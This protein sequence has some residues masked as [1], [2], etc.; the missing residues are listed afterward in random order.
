MDDHIVVCEGLCSLIGARPDMHIVGEASNGVEAVKNALA[1]HPDVILMDLV[2]PVMGGIEAIS[3][4]KRHDP[5][6]RILVLTSFNEDRRVYEAVKRGALG[7]LLKDSS[8][9]DLIRAVQQV[10]RGELSLQPSI[11]LKVIRELKQPS[12]LP[13]TT[14]PLSARE[15]DVLRLVARGCSVRGAVGR[16]YAV[17]IALG[18]LGILGARGPAIGCWILLGC[19]SVFALGS[20]FRLAGTDMGKA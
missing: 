17:G 6:A 14:D 8:S 20:G 11:A 16:L 19:V 18:V 5:E 10:H 12:D 2:M 3:E 9:T 15:A 13:R 7:Y 1:L 4:I